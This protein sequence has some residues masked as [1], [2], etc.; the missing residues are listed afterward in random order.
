MKFQKFICDF[1]KFINKGNIF[2][3]AI[4]MIIGTAFSAI[5][6]SLVKDIF[7]PFISLVIDFDLT[8]AK[9]I[10]RH[11]ILDA[12][13][14]VLKQAISLNYGNFLQ[15]IISFLI[16][17]LSIYW[18]VK[19][20]ISL[21]NHYVKEQVKYVKKL[22]RKHPELFDEE[23]EIGTIMYEKLK[24]EHPEYFECEIVETIEQAQIEA[25]KP[26]PQEVANQ[27]LEEINETLKSLTTKKEE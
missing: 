3:L 19:I 8:S 17:A 26:D 9:V 13:G 10:L 23:G 1:K 14:N 2:D 7:M 11:E 6:N 20:V 21:Q 22:K 24:K 27:L 25:E 5:V 15:N 12:E 18:A 16:I 4:G